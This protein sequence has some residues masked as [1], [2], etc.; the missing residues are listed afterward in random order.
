MPRA[1]TAHRQGHG[2]RQYGIGATEEAA[3]AR[4]AAA[5]GAQGFPGRP[6]GDSQTL[7]ETDARGGLS[8]LTAVKSQEVL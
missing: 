7:Q 6:E 2:E 4:F 5:S 3:S 8:D 1:K